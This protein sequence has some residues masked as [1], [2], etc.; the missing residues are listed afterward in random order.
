VSLRVLSILLAILMEG[1][2]E[3]AGIAETT[4]ATHDLIG[5]VRSVTIKKLGYSATEN[6]DRAGHLIEAVINMAHANTATYS[7][8]RYDQAGHLQEELVL[9]P[10]GRLIFRKRNVYAQDEEGRDSAS[11]TIS[12]NGGFQHAEFSL[13]DQRGHLAEQLWVDDS[14]AYKSLFDVFGR[15]IYSARYRKG[16]LFSELKHQY[17]AWGRL[18]ELVIY[19]GHG[20]MAGRVANDYDDRGRRVRATT[21]AFGQDHQQKWITTYEYD[22]MGNWIKEVTAE[23]SSPSSPNATASALPLVQERLIQYYHLTENTTP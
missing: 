20:T 9:D 22:D 14:I 23:H 3:T 18:H 7:L 11:V 5:P 15:R 10:S 21:E 2:W 8:F 16:E 19:N 4:R 12:E 13:Y 6:Y 17:D 1:F